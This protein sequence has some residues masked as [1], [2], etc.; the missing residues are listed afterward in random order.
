[1]KKV[2]ILG[3]SLALALSASAVAVIYDVEITERNLEIIV[4]PNSFMSIDAEV[5]THI[6]VSSAEIISLVMTAEKPLL[7]KNT[8][9][10]RNN[11]FE[12]MY[13]F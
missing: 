4:Q 11:N 8:A 1:M 12:R 9:V 3:I 7:F 2:L 10:K 6:P 5:P 13:H